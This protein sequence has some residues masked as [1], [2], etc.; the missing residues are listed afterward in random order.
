MRADPNAL[1][2]LRAQVARIERGGAAR[3]S[4]TLPF[5]IPAID[6]ALPG[7]GLAKAALHEV[8]GTGMDIELAAAPALFAAGILARRSGPV[9]WVL[10][11]RD[12]F[13]PG[14]AAAGLHPARVI[15]A[16][17]GS[18]AALPVMEEGLRHPGL[19][20]VVAEVSVPVSLTQS[21]RLHLAAQAG[22]AMAL[23]L[24]RRT[25]ETGAIAA[26]TRW[27]IG[28]HPSG[29]AL[30]DHPDTPGLGRQRWRL[31]LT[32][33]RGGQTGTWVVEACDASGRLGVVPLLAYESDPPAT[34]EA[35]LQS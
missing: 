33:C 13:A 15:Y 32:R 28:P 29:P 9:L 4:D 18:K 35:R 7:G 11:R 10:E 20:G 30:P 34:V 22:G 5:G 3:P 12:L 26:V 25:D 6:E 21:R 31:E 17:A 1:E 27:R 19:A 24:R 14:L 8:I 23:L 16:E 2:A